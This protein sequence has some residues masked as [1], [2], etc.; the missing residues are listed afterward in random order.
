MPSMDTPAPFKTPSVT[1]PTGLV[2]LI[3]QASGASRA[4]S[5]AYST[6]AGMV[7]RAMAQPPTPTV[8]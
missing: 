3:I 8:S 6:I 5:F 4:T 2:K 1:M 7:A